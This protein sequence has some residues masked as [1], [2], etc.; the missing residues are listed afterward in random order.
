[1][2]NT[3]LRITIFSII[4]LVVFPFYAISDLLLQTIS[5]NGNCLNQPVD[6]ISKITFINDTLCI[7]NFSN[8]TK[9][10]GGHIKTRHD[11]HFLG[12]QNQPFP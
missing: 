1:M 8:I 5:E 12:A 10:V 6:Q 11:G 3:S 9:F 7:W 2:V 4:S